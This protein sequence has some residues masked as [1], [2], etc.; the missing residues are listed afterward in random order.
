MTI[1]TTLILVCLVNKERREIKTTDQNGPNVT[2]DYIV[3][4]CVFHFDS[5]K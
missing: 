5:E 1:K 3:Y 2:P 4:K